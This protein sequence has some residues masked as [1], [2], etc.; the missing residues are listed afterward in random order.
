MAS[1]WPARALAMGVTDN[2]FWKPFHERAG[3][4]RRR[5]VSAQTLG[6]GL[7]D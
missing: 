6:F 2:Y 5:A 4:A 3:L 1:I 7:R